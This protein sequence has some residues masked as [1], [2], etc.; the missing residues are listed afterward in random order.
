MRC[1]IQELVGEN[2]IT[3]DDGQIVYDFIHPKLL[4]QESVEL[5]FT[6]VE[7][8]ASPFFN[9][10][11]GQLLS[12][13]DADSLNRFLKFKHLSAV[14]KDA[15]K[16]SIENAKEYYSNQSVRHAIDDAFDERERLGL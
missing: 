7:V 16:R 8:F 4:K 3:M 6:G 2:C 1:S 14:G 15:L 11:I 12:D 13:L 5:D 9:V 10:A